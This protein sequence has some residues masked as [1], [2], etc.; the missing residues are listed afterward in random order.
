MRISRLIVNLQWRDLQ[1]H[2][3]E[4]GLF[5]LVKS[6]GSITYGLLTWAL[7][8]QFVFIY[9]YIYFNPCLTHISTNLKMFGI[10]FGR[11]YSSTW[12]FPQSFHSFLAI[13]I[14]EIIRFWKT[15][16]L[17]TC[18]FIQSFTALFANYMA[19]VNLTWNLVNRKG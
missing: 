4:N 3:V 7:Y 13:Q 19:S 1:D 18:P 9:S 5:W 10:T 16:I 17:S 6:S 11:F 15:N 14:I 12:L 2:T 8:S